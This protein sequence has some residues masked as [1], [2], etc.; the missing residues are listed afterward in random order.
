MNKKIIFFVFSLTLASLGSVS[1]DASEKNP[2]SYRKAKKL[3]RLDEARREERPQKCPWPGCF[4]Q[5]YSGPMLTEHIRSQHSQVMQASF[6]CPDCGANLKGKDAGFGSL[7]DHNATHGIRRFICGFQECGLGFDTLTA[8]KK[9]THRGK[10]KKKPVLHREDAPAATTAVAIVAP[11]EAS[12]LVPVA[13]VQQIVPTSSS[14]FTTASTALSHGVSYLTALSASMSTV[15]AAA[16][17]GTEHAV[18]QIPDS[19]SSLVA[20]VSQEKPAIQEG[21]LEAS[22]SGTQHLAQ[23]SKAEEIPYT[24]S[25]DDF[26]TDNRLNG[27]PSPSFSLHS[28]S[29]TP[30]VTP[31][32]VS[33]SPS[34]SSESEDVLSERDDSAT[35]LIVTMKASGEVDL[36]Q[37][38]PSQSSPQC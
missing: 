9:H 10:A 36:S 15:Q 6:Q 18:E 34:S 32:S 7:R 21:G 24:F 17:D 26:F 31:C 2:S 23:T 25:W 8:L 29:S 38:N 14:A 20:T 28:T 27:E 22:E 3:R 1:L 30:S 11:S 12:A 35:P 19:L 16:H 33:S 37:M 13:P 5:L 4:E